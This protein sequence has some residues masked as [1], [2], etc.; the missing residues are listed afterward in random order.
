ML[1]LSENPSYVFIVLKTLKML[2]DSQYPDDV[3]I[4]SLSLSCFHFSSICQ[5]VF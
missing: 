3:V 4:F 5:N 1:T 2:L